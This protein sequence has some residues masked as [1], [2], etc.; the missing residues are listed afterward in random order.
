MGNNFKCNRMKRFLVALFI[1]INVLTLSAK[2]SAFLVGIGNYNTAKTGFGVIH[3][4]NDVALLEG[5][6]RGKGFEISKLV[7]SQATKSNIISSLNNLLKNTTSGDTVY[8]HFSGHG[9]LIPDMNNDEKG[10]YDQSFVCYD[11]C[12]SSNIG[13]YI[14]QNHLIDDELFS[15]LNKIKRKVRAKGAVYVVFDACYSA[16]SDR[17]P[18]QDDDTYDESDVVWLDRTRGAKDKFFAN[19]S[20]KDY[21]RK[22]VKPGNYSGAG[23]ITIINACE[24]DKKTYECRDRRTST[25]FGSLSYCIGKML[26]TNIPMSSWEDFF[27]SGKFRRYK[28]FSPSQNPVVE[29]H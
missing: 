14:G 2:K 23:K 7:D 19:S 12:Y 6:L 10:D 21:L 20:A 26:D 27:K 29:S 24:S 9:Q 4:N 16:G 11:A 1:I 25:I 18:I 3:G 13:N 8:I 22:L 15:Y 5:K 28:I 17:S